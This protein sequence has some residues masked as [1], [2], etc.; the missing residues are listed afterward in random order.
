MSASEALVTQKTDEL[1]RMMLNLQCTPVQ[2]RPS[3]AAQLEQ[4]IAG[5]VQAIA[6]VDFTAESTQAAKARFKSKRNKRGKDEKPFGA[7]A[8]T[9]PALETSEG[10]VISA[11]TASTPV[12]LSDKVH[13][14]RADLNSRVNKYFVEHEAAASRAVRVLGVWAHDSCMGI[15]KRCGYFGVGLSRTQSDQ[16][17]Q[18][19]DSEIFN[20]SP[21]VPGPRSLVPVAEPFVGSATVAVPERLAAHCTRTSAPGCQQSIR[22]H[23]AQTQPISS[24]HH[25]DPSA[26][27][28]AGMSA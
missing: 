20:T 19:A 4:R 8:Q 15:A 22:Q 5:I 14:N 23:R 6:A 2:E 18:K 26:S 11:R 25:R 13:L 12:R 3:Q 17:T 10:Y 9:G 1:A 28:S 7:H 27:R 21:Y 24:K 16:I